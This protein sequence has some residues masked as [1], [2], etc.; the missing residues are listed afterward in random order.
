MENPAAERTATASSSGKAGRGWSRAD[1]LACWL[2]MVVGLGL[3]VA[4]H[5]ATLA[6]YGTLEY[7]A[8]GYRFFRPSSST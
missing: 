1:H 2:C 5:L 6:R 8:D 3:A 4:P 7:L